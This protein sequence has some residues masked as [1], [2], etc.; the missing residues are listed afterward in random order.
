[1][2]E[3]KTGTETL[4]EFEE[5]RIMIE[6]ATKYDLVTEVVY[7]FAGEIAEGASIFEASH[8]ALREWDIA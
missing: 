1:M 5:I 4:K 7:S 2:M 8:C 6:M 3:I